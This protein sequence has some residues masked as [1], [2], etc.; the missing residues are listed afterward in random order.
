MESSTETQEELKVQQ[1]WTRLVS[2]PNMS[3]KDRIRKSWV[4]FVTLGI[5]TWDLR[6]ATCYINVLFVIYFSL[7]LIFLFTYF[8]LGFNFR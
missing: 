4:C 7:A 6:K 5:W 2:V 8:F 3:R 1:K